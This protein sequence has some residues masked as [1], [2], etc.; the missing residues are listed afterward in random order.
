[1]SEHL[2]PLARTPIIRAGKRRGSPTGGR[3]A[4]ESQSSTAHSL[5]KSMSGMRAVFPNVDDSNRRVEMPA[6]HCIRECKI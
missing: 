3:N 4:K 6:P 5:F 2:G 1:M